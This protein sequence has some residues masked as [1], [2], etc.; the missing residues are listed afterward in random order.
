MGLITS[1]HMKVMKEYIPLKNLRLVQNGKPKW[2]SIEMVKCLHAKWNAHN[3]L[4]ISDM[5][6]NEPSTVL[7]IKQS[8]IAMELHFA[9]QSK[10]NP[11][12]F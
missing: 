4:N 7:Y 3:R 1:V 9:N 2:W 12:E 5:M 6:R 10:T 11:E 8:K